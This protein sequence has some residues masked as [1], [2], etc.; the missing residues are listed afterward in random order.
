VKSIGAFAFSGCARLENITIPDGLTSI[1]QSVF[2]SCRR[3]ARISIPDSVKTI[4]ESAFCGSG[5]SSV[6]IP[7]RVASI[8]SQAFKN[9]ENLKT[10]FYE[11]STVTWGS[12]VFYGTTLLKVCVSPD[13]GFTNFSEMVITPHDNDDECKSF[14]NYFNS[15]FK[16]T[17][18]DG[19]VLQEK[20]RST[21]EWEGQASECAEYICYND[22][23]FVAWSKC[24]S[25]DTLTRICEIGKC[26]EKGDSTPSKT[27]IEVRLIDAVNISSI[28]IVELLETLSNLSGV[29]TEEL[30]IGW[31]T[32]EDGDVISIIF[33]IEDE[34]K[35][36]AIARKIDDIDEGEGCEYGVLCKVK[37]VQV[38]AKEHDIS[39]HQ[40]LKPNR[41]YRQNRIEVHHYRTQ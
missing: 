1:E 24:N 29:D 28:N 16:G 37:S 3:L 33:Y 13:Y 27:S 23:G 32:D 11:G 8:G 40:R 25:T 20:R 2:N 26:V 9:C 35:A 30:S 10:V 5:I 4:G 6:N 7:E 41:G 12:D 38:I 17:Y 34:E 36:R 15:C 21:K 39:A 31:E 14:Y 18:K 22:S 19:R